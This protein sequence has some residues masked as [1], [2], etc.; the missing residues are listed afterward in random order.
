MMLIDVPTRIPRVALP[1]RRGKLRLGLFTNSFTTSSWTADDTLE[2]AQ[3]TN[4]GHFITGRASEQ[5]AALYSKL[6]VLQNSSGSP[7]ITA[8]YKNSARTWQVE[9][10]GGNLRLRNVDRTWKRSEVGCQAVDGVGVD[11]V[12][13]PSSGVCADRR[14]A[15]HWIGS[16]TGEANSNIDAALHR[17]AGVVPEQSTEPGGAGDLTHLDRRLRLGRFLAGRWQVVTSTVRAFVVV[18]GHRLAGDVIEVS[19]CGGVAG[20]GGFAE[21]PDGWMCDAG[22]RRAIRCDR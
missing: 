1:P 19:F 22:S 21:G 12:S 16:S 2:T 8:R 11:R 18:P 13:S 7:S 3:R 14:R 4:L 17:S 9:F 5:L 20:S 15:R 10:Q 6:S